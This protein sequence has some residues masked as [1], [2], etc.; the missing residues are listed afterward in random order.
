MDSARNPGRRVGE[1]SLGGA[2]D[3]TTDPSDTDRNVGGAKRP[4]A[5]GDERE[6]CW[7]GPI[8]H[9]KVTAYNHALCHAEIAATSIARPETQPTFGE[10]SWTTPTPYGQ[11]GP[12]LDFLSSASTYASPRRDSGPEA[13]A[14]STDLDPIGT[15]AIALGTE[16]IRAFAKSILR[17]DQAHK[18]WIIKAAEAF[19]AGK[20]LPKAAQAEEGEADPGAPDRTR[21]RPLPSGS[22]P[23]PGQPRPVQTPHP[24]TWKRGRPPFPFPLSRYRDGLA[25]VGWSVVKLRYKDSGRNPTRRIRGGWLAPLAPLYGRKTASGHFQCG[26]RSW[27]WRAIWSRPSM[28]RSRS[29]PASAM[30]CRRCYLRRSIAIGSYP[31]DGSATETGPSSWLEQPTGFAPFRTLLDTTPSGSLAYKAA[32]TVRQCLG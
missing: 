13:S 6:P 2:G 16:A 25:R 30:P 23:D 4:V 7:Y 22:S 28:T 32:G 29:L 26:K 14:S 27:L 10:G 15:A 8:Y 31:M 9:N 1:G 20:A 11:T 3:V 12:P 21:L 17:G 19:V 18:D 24:L 5:L